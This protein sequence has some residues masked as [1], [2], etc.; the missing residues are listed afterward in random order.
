MEGHERFSI[1]V[2]EAIHSS[3]K[4]IPFQIVVEFNVKCEMY[5]RPNARCYPILVTQFRHALKII[6]QSQSMT[7]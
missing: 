4:M 7:H 3:S 1:E 5:P 2:M 6:I